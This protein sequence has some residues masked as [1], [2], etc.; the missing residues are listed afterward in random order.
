[1]TTLD[2]TQP[3]WDAVWRFGVL[4]RR[5]VEHLVGNGCTVCGEP[6]TYV[7]AGPTW[8]V[9]ILHQH[10]GQDTLRISDELVIRCDQH[11]PTQ[12]QEEAH[13]H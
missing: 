4:L 3:P 9:E 1:M 2:Y 5:R 10:T 12:S 6:A 7:Q 13:A 8:T 11:R